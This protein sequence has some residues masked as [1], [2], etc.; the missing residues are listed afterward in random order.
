MRTKNLALQLFMSV[1]FFTATAQTAYDSIS[2]LT[3]GT[4]RP[5]YSSSA[6]IENNYSPTDFSRVQPI[7]GLSL[8]YRFFQFKSHALSADFKYHRVRYKNSSFANNLGGRSFF[9]ADKESSTRFE[10]G[11]SYNYRY[12]ISPRFSL[13]FGGGLGFEFDTNQQ[14]YSLFS[15]DE[16]GAIISGLA[17]YESDIMR[18]KYNLRLSGN[19]LTSGGEFAAFIEKNNRYSNTVRNSNIVSAN[20]T[21]NVPNEINLSGNATYFGV[22]F[23][24]KKSKPKR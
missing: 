13:N 3:I 19:Y 10:F 7:D 17:R 6:R 21:V 15:T 8:A 5:I 16:S 4:F 24:P 20:P 12:S 22:M 18:F 23:T 11:L 9:L 14:A 1:C 2:R